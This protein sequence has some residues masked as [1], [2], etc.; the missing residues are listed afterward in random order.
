MRKDLPNLK[1]IL[2]DDDTLN[3]ENCPTIND[4]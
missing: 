4:E 1:I 2:I 3:L